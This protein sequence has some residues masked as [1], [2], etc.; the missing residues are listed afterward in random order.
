ML[1]FLFF[2]S[3]N[4]YPQHNNFTPRKKDIRHSTTNN[5]PKI[6]LINQGKD[7][8]PCVR[9][10]V[11][12]RVRVRVCACVHGRE[13]GRVWVCVWAGARWIR[14][15]LG[16]GGAESVGRG[17][18]GGAG[19]SRA[20]GVGGCGR[21]VV[22]GLGHVMGDGGSCAGGSSGS[23]GAVEMG[24]G[25]RADG[26]RGTSERANASE[27]KGRTGV[28]RGRVGPRLASYF[29]GRGKILG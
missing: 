18:A 10:Y 2:F 25:C 9:A 13:P 19:G 14:D 6:Y 4:I 11:C 28:N 21:W 24:T 15:L 17:M 27:R 20:G 5:L 22:E 29:F 16:G 23:G 12:G 3:K 26:R 1:L 8:R 7:P